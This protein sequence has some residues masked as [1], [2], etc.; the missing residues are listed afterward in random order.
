MLFLLELI[1]FYVTNTL[2][3]FNFYYHL[4][5]FVVYLIFRSK[6]IKILFKIEL[7]NGMDVLFDFDTPVNK[8]HIISCIAFDGKINYSNFR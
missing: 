7:A 1:L 2:F 6:L 8:S 3:Q 4:T 5:G